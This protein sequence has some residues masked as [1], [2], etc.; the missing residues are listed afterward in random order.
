MF[1]VPKRFRM[2]SGVK[3]LDIVE[4]SLFGTLQRTGGFHFERNGC[5]SEQQRIRDGNAHH[6]LGKISTEGGITASGTAR[7]IACLE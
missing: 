4:D 1:R 5:G 3:F 6:A 2:D 7:Q